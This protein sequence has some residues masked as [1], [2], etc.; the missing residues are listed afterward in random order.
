MPFKAL[1]AHIT[2]TRF[3]VS[4]R[5]IE[6]WPLVVRIINGKRHADTAHA[7][8]VAETM[9][10]DAPAVATGSPLHHSRRKP[11]LV[12]DGSPK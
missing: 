7:L 11:R 3:S 1:A 4:P 6:R 9:I 2:K 12:A 5:T 8:S 10:K